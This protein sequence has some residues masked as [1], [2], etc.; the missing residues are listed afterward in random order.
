MLVTLLAYSPYGPGDR[1]SEDE[2]ADP[3]THRI[4]LRGGKGKRCVLLLRASLGPEDEDGGKRRRSISGWRGLRLLDAVGDFVWR[5][6]TLYDL[7]DQDVVHD[8]HVP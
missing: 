4:W 2:K 1:F 5:L 8:V 3:H 6:T 7:A